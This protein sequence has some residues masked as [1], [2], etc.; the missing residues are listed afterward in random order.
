MTT[1]E[2]FDGNVRTV[3][4]TTIYKTVVDYVYYDGCKIRPV[5]LDTLLAAAHYTPGWGRLN[6]IQGGLSKKVKKS[7]STHW[8]L[9]A[10]DISVRGRGIDQPLVWK[11]C[12]NLF[13]TGNLPFPRGYAGD[14]FDK[15]IHGIYAPA[16][17]GH[18]QLQA[19]YV[20]WSKYRG[21]GLVGSKHYT[22]P[23]NERIT[24]WRD[25]MFNPTNRKDG[26]WTLYVDVASDSQLL[27]LDRDRHPKVQRERGHSLNFVAQVYRWGRNNYLTAKDTFY[28]ADYLTDN[29]PNN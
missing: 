1:H 3:F 2:G 29:R 11:F 21:D 16:T 17:F 7:A 6:L 13:E 10:V 8:L 22:G 19:Q 25:S 14:P 27:G 9:D 28:A 5:H 15:H 24:P 18:A 12:D 20:E 26:K 23:V 4:Q